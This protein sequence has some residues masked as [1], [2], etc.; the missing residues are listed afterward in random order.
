MASYKT[1]ASC[2]ITWLPGVTPIPQSF[3]TDWA[4]L[5]D[6]QPVGRIA[7]EI[8]MLEASSKERF[9]SCSFLP[10]NST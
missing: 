8:V 5:S 7:K 3:N 9:F 4:L 1:T 6:E 10:Y 2:V